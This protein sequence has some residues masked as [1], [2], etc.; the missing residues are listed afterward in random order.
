M[1]KTVGLSPASHDL[2]TLFGVGVTGALSD[3]QLL[4]RFAVAK[5]AEVFEAIV[6]RHGPMVWGVCRR[7]LGNHHD[8]EDAF[9]ATF[10]V[11]ARRA[12]SVFPRE[13]V[14]NW[15]YG[16]AHKTATK[17]RTM[18]VKRLRREVPVA[19]VPETGAKR[20]EDRNDLLPQLD[21][22]LSR[23]PKKY[24]IPIV[25][26]ELE[27]KT[28]RQAA[29]I[30]G[31]PIGTV[32]GRLSTARAILAKRLLRRGLTLA[33]GSLATLLGT[34][35]WSAGVPSNLIVSTARGASLI[36]SSGALTP[37]M[38]SAQ[39]AALAEE[40]LKMMILSKMKAGLAVL[41][42]GGF[43]ALVWTGLAFR[44]RAAG[45][46]EQAASKPTTP[47]QSV[48]DPVIDRVLEARVDTARRVYEG[49]R[50]FIHSSPQSYENAPIWSRRWMEAEVR[51]AKR[52]PD[53]V[54][55]AQRHLDRMKLMETMMEQILKSE[56]FAA[57][58]LLKAKYFRL[59][60]EELLIDLKA[61]RNWTSSAK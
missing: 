19:E 31:W 32:S 54:A 41:L 5:D 39:A 10:I 55:A 51:L 17:A 56:P 22:E 43:F 4:D 6:D 9:Q 33:A 18:K 3:G 11:L 13:N 29:E 42:V 45:A 38:V 21:T 57:H 7:V 47:A 49:E 23:L 1:E 12:A 20:D 34:E 26:C 60:A 28:H 36:A 58:N 40:V 35:A 53:R 48:W 15:L 25:L 27:G 52:S 46:Q 14:A 8:A 2:Q 59:E 50:Q 16:V 61:G 24:R 30:L 44:L 37:G